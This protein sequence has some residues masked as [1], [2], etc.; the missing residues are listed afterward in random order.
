MKKFSSTP[1]PSVAGQ[2][3]LRTCLQRSRITF[4]SGLCLVVLFG[5]IQSQ[6]QA[7][8]GSFRFNSNSGPLIWNFDGLY[9]HHTAQGRLVDAGGVT[10]GSVAG[11]DG[12]IKVRL[13]Y[14][15][16]ISHMVIPFFAY[17]QVIQKSRVHLTLDPAT[18]QLEGE[19]R[20]TEITRQ[21]Q[22]F[23]W[24]EVKHLGTVSY[25]EPIT[26]PVPPP[27]DGSWTLDL[28]IVPDENKLSGDATL[29][30]PNGGNILFS[31]VGTYSPVKQQSKIILR[32]V[33]PNKGASLVLVAS[34]PELAI[35]SMRGRVCGQTVR[36][37]SAD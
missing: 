35:S 5:N 28:N 12:N 1:E 27:I 16:E 36:F 3:I 6:A 37:P 23:I 19:A 32:S 9:S 7:P 18:R 4:L 15:E 30:F 26:V 24:T 8:V 21:V 13:W 25:V 2:S 10:Y 17:V 33:A 29:S 14:R 31:L 22:Q 34:G 11:A 20:I